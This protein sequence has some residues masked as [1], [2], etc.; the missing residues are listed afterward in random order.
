MF[1]ITFA[2]SVERAFLEMDLPEKPLIDHE[3][4]GL[5]VFCTSHGKPL[6]C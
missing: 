1:A 4:L 2:G 3:E 5:D 6:H